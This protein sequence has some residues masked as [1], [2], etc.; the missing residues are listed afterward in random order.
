MTKLLGRLDV[1]LS[2]LSQQQRQQLTQKLLAETKYQRD[3]ALQ[4]VKIAQDRVNAARS[5]AELQSAKKD[6]EDALAVVAKFEQRYSQLE[7]GR[8]LPS[9]FYNR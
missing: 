5:P 1:A 8:D 9:D 7:L 4:R 3:A 2:P 6:L